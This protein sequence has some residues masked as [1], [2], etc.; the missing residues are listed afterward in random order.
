M[1]QR[2][3]LPLMCASTASGHLPYIVATARPVLDGIPSQPRAAVQVPAQPGACIV[4]PGLCDE[5]GDHVDHSNHQ[6]SATNTEWPVSMGFVELSRESGEATP[7][8][9]IDAGRASDFTPEEAPL[10]S[11]RLRA[12]ADAVDSM[13]ASVRKGQA[14]ARLRAAR[15]GADEAFAE[16]LTIMEDAVVNRGAD[17][18]DVGNRVLELMSQVRAEAGE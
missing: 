4:Y 2:T 15:E 13:A 14:L 6:L 7:L 16:I 18:A 8:L 12:A 11:A 1:K 10:I 9:Y 5:T 3:T 17:P